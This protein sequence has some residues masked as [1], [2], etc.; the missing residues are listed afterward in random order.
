MSR[1]TQAQREGIFA[2]ARANLQREPNQRE[3]I[4]RRQSVEGLIYKTH[5]ND[6]DA[7]AER[8][9]SGSELAWWQWVDAR[10]DARLEVH[11]E[12]VGEAI[13]EYCGQQVAALKR[14]LECLRRE[15]TVQRGSGVSTLAWMR[16]WRE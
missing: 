16:R 2:E 1:F 13:G 8:V 15:L 10:L 14:E 3:P 5:N 11:S 9:A 6:D 12:A 4:E 7:P